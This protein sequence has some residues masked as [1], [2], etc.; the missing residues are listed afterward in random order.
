M[1]R[2]PCWPSTRQIVGRQLPNLRVKP[3]PAFVRLIKGGEHSSGI[4]TSA[5]VVFYLC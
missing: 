2:R 1:L 5:S 3:A 4:T